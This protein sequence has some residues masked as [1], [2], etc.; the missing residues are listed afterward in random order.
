MKN[1]YGVP[2][3]SNGYAPSLFDIYS[4]EC[5]VCG[6]KTDLQRHEVFHGPN[7]TRSKALG[8]W[9]VLCAGCHMRLHHR[10]SSLD[11]WLKEYGQRIAMSHY[12]WGVDDFRQRF[13]KNYLEDADE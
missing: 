10:D 5:Y 4:S 13:G 2:L 1:E 12:G 9:A 3:D 11:W 7:R 6:K 8:L